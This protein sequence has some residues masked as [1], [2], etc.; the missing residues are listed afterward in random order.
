MKS[1]I[2]PIVLEESEGTWSVSVPGLEHKGAATWGRTQDE[3]LRN[4]QEVMQMVI[5]EML[6]DREP[7]PDVVQ[8]SDHPSVA[9]NV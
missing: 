9:V 4:I 3:A 1:Y 5:E 6:E 8:V 7:L 2:F